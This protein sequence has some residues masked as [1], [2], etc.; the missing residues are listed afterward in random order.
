[1]RD[2]GLNPW[3]NFNESSDYKL[4]TNSCIDFVYA[5]LNTG[6]INSTGFEG[7]LVPRWNRNNINELLGDFGAQQD[8]LVSQWNEL[9][10]GHISDELASALG[11]SPD[12]MNGFLNENNINYS[13]INDYLNYGL[14]M[15]GN[16]YI[17]S[18]GTDSQFFADDGTLLGNIQSFDP[19]NT[20]LSLGTMASTSWA[21][22][23]MQSVF[24]ED[25]IMALGT[26]SSPFSTDDSLFNNYMFYTQD[27]QFNDNWSN[28]GFENITWDAT[29]DEY[30]S[31]LD[32]V[33]LN[34]FNDN[35]YSFDDFNFH[36]DNFELGLYDNF[37][38]LNDYPYSNDTGFT[39]NYDLDFDYIDYGSYDY[40]GYDSFDYFWLPVVLDLDGDGV[41]LT[42]VLNSKA[43]FD[44]TGDGTK[45]QT[46]WVG[47]DDGLLTY[48]ENSDG[49]I[50]TAREIAFA[51]RTEANDTDLEALKAEFD[52]NDDGLL[53]INDAQF[54]KFKIWQ[55]KDSDGESDEGELL[56]LTQADIASINLVG[57]KID[58]YAI[59][60]NKIHAFTMYTKSDRSIG[61][62]SDVAL[63]YDDKG[64]T[65]NVKNGYMTIKQMGGNEIY[66]IVTDTKGVKLDTA[67]LGVD[68]AIGGSGNDTL[69]VSSSLNPKDV[70]LHGEAGNDM[71]SG[72]NGND[73][74]NGGDGNDILN[75]G[76]G[77][78]TLIVDGSDNLSKLDGGAGFDTLVIEG[79][80]GSSINLISNRVES[81]FGS[82]GNDIFDGLHDG[83]YYSRESKIIDGRGGNDTAIGSNALDML[84]GG[85]GN[86]ILNGAGDND[87]YYYNRGDGDDTIKEYSRSRFDYYSNF[88]GRTFVGDEEEFGGKDTIIFGDGINIENILF[89]NHNSNLVLEIRDENNL[90]DGKITIIDQYS[91]Q[92][93]VD[94]ERAGDTFYRN[95]MYA[96]SI[97]SIEFNDGKIYNIFDFKVGTSA[98]DL[99]S[100][101]SADER[102][103]GSDGNDTISYVSC[104]KGATVNLSI[105]T[106]QDTIGGGKDTISGIENI[107]GTRYNDILN[108]N[109]ENNIIDGGIGADT[110]NGGLGHDIYYIDNRPLAKLKKVV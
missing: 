55:D 56:T 105:A 93:I 79:D 25:A 42:S 67:R 14:L 103:F 81:V 12:V 84:I 3:E 75:G 30:S 65:T 24:T 73:W 85:I 102:I 26:F 49:L 78:D 44:V 62:G 39:Y 96:R 80:K 34:D 47:A 71:L 19:E 6:G 82:D 38:N 16:N 87:K 46:G 5:A 29:Q 98:S 86:D 52:S 4:L 109:N 70:I 11:L 22:E 41:E 17:F 90:I 8:M 66:A 76:F 107:I 45:H 50:M 69:T 74:L 33:N 94:R 1:M 106:L 104:T 63:G 77:D 92:N 48:D 99:L 83:Q 36:G 27:D 2:F 60:G 59:D 91:K 95:S 68:G 37:I 43:W 61:M 88:F 40:Y 100:S 58:S 89:S 10:S 72:G 32:G 13:N 53:D 28:S 21:L 97:E 108:G 9:A 7:D 110:L 101:T 54:N 15:D 23:N 51:Y 35:R 57:S 20:F 31:W 18:N 64:Y